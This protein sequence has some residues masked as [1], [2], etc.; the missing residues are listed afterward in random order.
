MK[1]ACRLQPNTQRMHFDKA[2]THV[3]DFHVEKW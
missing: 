1:A 2:I 3:D